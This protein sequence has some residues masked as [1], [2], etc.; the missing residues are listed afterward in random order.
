MT[1][2]GVAAQEVQPALTVLATEVQRAADEQARASYEITK[3][4]A[5]EQEARAK[6][7]QATLDA[8]AL[9][10]P[11]LTEQELA[12]QRTTLELNKLAS[13]LGQAALA[14]EA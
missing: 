10:N 13:A 2:L 6:Q 12:Y 8:I 14:A 7:S 5:L 11:A 9:V 3:A 1:R 4:L